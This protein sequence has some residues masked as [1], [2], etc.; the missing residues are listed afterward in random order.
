[1]ANEHVTHELWHE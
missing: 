1:M